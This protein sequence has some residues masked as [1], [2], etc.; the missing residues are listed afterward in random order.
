VEALATLPGIGRKTALRLALHLLKQPVQEV[1]RL[2]GALTNL[3]RNARRCSTCHNL[4]DDDPCAIC[5]SPRRD[6]NLLCV[7]AESQDVLA[8]EKTGQY[9][10]HYHV[11]GGIIN[12]MG[13]VSPADLHIDSLCSRVQANPQAE[14]IL[15]LAA[16][17]EGDTTA[18]YLARRLQPLGVRV[19][20]I[21][22]GVPVGS[23]LEYT[24]ELTL[25][26]S[27]AQRVVYELRS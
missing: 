14:V 1:E 17:M 20:S 6:P 24:D 13:G 27:L 18:F 15:A 9:N 16:S 7:V 25:A 8:I 22:R 5:R 11:L 21:A 26:R 2:A 23:E 4:T 19:S 3:A 10:G 12:P